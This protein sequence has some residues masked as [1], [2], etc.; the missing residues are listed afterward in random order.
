VVAASDALNGAL[1]ADY[2]CDGIDDQEE[3]QRALDALPLSGGLVFLTEGNYYLSAP[4]RITKPATIMGTG[5]GWIPTGSAFTCLRLID[6]ANCNAIEIDPVVISEPIM[7]ENLY[8]YGNGDNQTATSHGIVM[9]STQNIYHYVVMRN[10]TVNH[11]RDDAVRICPQSRPFA[12]LWVDTLICSKN[13]GAGLRIDATLF[14]VSLFHLTRVR[15]EINKYGLYALGNVSDVVFIESSFVSNN[16]EGIRLENIAQGISFVGSI[17]RYNSQEAVETYP[18]VYISGSRGIQFVSPKMWIH[19]FS[20]PVTQA[21]NIVNS[22]DCL[23]ANALVSGTRRGAIRL[24]GSHFISITGGIFK[25][26]CR[27]KNDVY[28]VILLTDDGVN[29][30]TDNLIEGNIIRETADNRARY[31]VRED[32]PENDRNMVI[33]NRIVG[34]VGEAISLQGG[35]SKEGYNIIE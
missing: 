9:P 16:R 18:D 32:A 20:S 35:A 34:V 27:G 12:D 21:F 24:Q 19:S 33:G 31:G 4:I 2:I 17:I 10:I 13:G 7:L 3:I 28:A 30:S 1:R 5:G 6:G 25:D 29:F 11:F 23:I 22:E 8:L 15:L 14:P 26:T